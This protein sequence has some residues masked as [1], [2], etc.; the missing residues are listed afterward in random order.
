AVGQGGGH[1][2]P[3]LA[4]GLHDERVDAGQGLGAGRAVRRPVVRGLVGGEVRDVVP[5]PR[6]L[7]FVPPDQGLA[8]APRLALGVGRGAVVDDAPVGG[9]GPAPLVRDPVLLL[10]RLA[11]GRLVD[12]AGVDAAVDPAAAH[13]RAV[14]V[15]LLVG[16][17]RV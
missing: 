17:N 3:R 5:G 1:V 11:A 12:A 2:Q 10:A 4:V 6:G 7:L 9:P 8:L 15:E 16:R 14:V 13:G